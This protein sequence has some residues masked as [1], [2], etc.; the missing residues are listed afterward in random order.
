FDWTAAE[1]YVREVNERG[2]LF[3]ADWRLPNLRE[4][5]TISEVNCQ[6]PRINLEAFPG[7][8]QGFYWTASRKLIE[9]PELA[10][11]AMSFGAEGMRVSRSVETHHVRLV[12]RSD[13]ALSDSGAQF[14]ILTSI[15]SIR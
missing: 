14:Q 13:H 8:A 6:D 1:S 11:F 2:D 10:A 5:A 7:T 12:R 15:R 3:Y 4:L 9:G